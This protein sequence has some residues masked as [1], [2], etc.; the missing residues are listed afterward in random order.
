MTNDDLIKESYGDFWD[1][2]KHSAD[3][4][5]WVYTKDLPN[6][7]D[8]YFEANIKK[9]IEFQKSFGASGENENYLTRG[10]RWRPKELSA[11]PSPHKQS[12]L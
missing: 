8:F 6:M 10:S 4:N 1:S 11:L 3:V 5:G 9:E 2:V 7:L 12:I